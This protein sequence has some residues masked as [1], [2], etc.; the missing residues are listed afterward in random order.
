MQNISI[1]LLKETKTPPDHRVVL[2]P[3]QCADLVRQHPEIN[4]IVQRSD[5]RAFKDE[6][7]SA[8]GL[9]LSDDL[10]NCDVLIG[11]KEVKIETL[12]PEKTYLFF[13]HTIKKQPHN[14]KLLRSLLDK[15]ITLIDWELIKDHS[16]KRL[17][18]FGRYAGIVGCY[19]GFRLFGLKHGLYELKPAHLCHNREELESELR[20]VSLPRNAKIVM[21]G[22][23][24][25]GNGALEI[26]ERLGLRKVGTEAFLNESFEEPVFT[27]PGTEDCFE[28]KAGGG[29][30]K[31]EFYRD[32]SGY[33]SRFQRFCHAADM[34]VA[35]HLWKA[36]SPHYFDPED[37]R[38]PD[39]KV[40]VVADVSC[41]VGG[42]VGT[43]IRSS[44]IEAPFFGFS[45]ETLAEAD[46]LLQGNI[47]VMAVDNLPCEMPKDASEDFGN[48]FIKHVLPRLIDGDS[49]GNLRAATE[50]KDG[51]LM[52]DFAYLEDYALSAR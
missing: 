27:H 22:F 50:T 20:K 34:Y 39:W 1:G 11:I 28:Q 21:T 12:I 44:S 17:I 30:E 5:I 3:R 8:L 32:P 9:Q 15:K 24:R 36:G 16:G 37:T 47:A 25:V 42:P 18:G 51:Q 10:S 6:E 45:P 38:H 2:T 7:Y 14:A 35:C 40:S 4:L 49:E 48:E 33:V 29:F 41:D 43:T 46:F 52:P 13:S 19:N 23:G 31:A 26:M